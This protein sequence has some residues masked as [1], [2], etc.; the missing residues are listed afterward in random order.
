MYLAK[1]N[2]GRGLLTP[3]ISHLAVPL[4][5]ILILYT[6]AGSWKQKLG[7]IWDPTIQ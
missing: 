1:S 6:V 3:S 2:L 5:V 7:S 4:F